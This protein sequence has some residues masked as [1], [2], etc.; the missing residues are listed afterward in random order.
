MLS[1]GVR[2]FDVGDKTE[3]WRMYCEHIS[4]WIGFGTLLYIRAGRV[5]EVIVSLWLGLRCVV[6][7]NIEGKT[8][9]GP[10]LM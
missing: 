2:K 3:F 6:G 1:S 8:W 10:R 7:E 9:D 5:K 4:R